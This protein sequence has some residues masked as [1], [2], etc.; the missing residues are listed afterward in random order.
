MSGDPSSPEGS[1]AAWRAEAA[2]PT[3]WSRYVEQATALVEPWAAVGR[4]AA[5]AAG[6]AQAILLLAARI[7]LSQA[8]FV[9][10]MMIMMRAEG[11]SVAAPVGATLIQSIA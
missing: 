4:R 2:A 11:F 5:V 10:Q 8:I 7:W 3:L 9:H 1:E 6:I